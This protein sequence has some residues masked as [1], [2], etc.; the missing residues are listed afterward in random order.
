VKGLVRRKG[1]LNP[2]NW[3][4]LVD[5]KILKHPR[6]GEVRT[7]VD[8]SKEGKKCGGCGKGKGKENVGCLVM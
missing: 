5:D 7:Q 2:L 6:I 8:L 3:V 1:D 4:L